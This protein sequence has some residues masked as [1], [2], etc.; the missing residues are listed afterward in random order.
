[1]LKK[2]VQSLLCVTL[3]FVLLDVHK[4]INFFWWPAVYQGTVVDEQGHPIPGA[5]VVAYSYQEKL[6]SNLLEG[7][8]YSTAHR[9]YETQ[10][11]YEGHFKIIIDR[12][13]IYNVRPPPGLLAVKNDYLADKRERVRPS[14]D[15][16][17]TLK[18]P[19]EP[20][21]YAHNLRSAYFFLSNEAA[22]PCALLDIGKILS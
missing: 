4:R 21:Q 22:P 1:M 3:I 2:I 9:Y 16:V 5:H 6:S 13:G 11:D 8:T 19:V 12:S 14:N 20:M 18:R 10:S 7:G 15:L 17:M